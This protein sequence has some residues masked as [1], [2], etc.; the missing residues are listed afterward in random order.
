MLKPK[1]IGNL[2]CSSRSIEE[3]LSSNK[4]MWIHMLNCYRREAAG[5]IQSLEKQIKK[6][7]RRET[8]SARGST[9]PTRASPSQYAPVSSEI[10]RTLAERGSVLHA[11]LVDCSSF[12]EGSG[13]IPTSPT[14]EAGTPKLSLSAMTPPKSD[15]TPTGAA[16][17]EGNDT[18]Q[19][20]VNVRRFS[21]LNIRSTLKKT[22]G[23]MGNDKEKIKAWFES[24]KDK[25]STLYEASVSYYMISQ[26]V[27]LPIGQIVSEE[28]EESPANVPAKSEAVPAAMSAQAEKVELLC[29]PL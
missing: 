12:I 4:H 29:E 15:A 25:L 26:D 1:E 19:P 21:A 16:Q 13:S 22:Q 27:F 24:M 3:A 5:R 2:M 28:R 14:K 11:T 18:P 7:L 20:K 8:G 23:I 9:T 10:S 6:Q 17:G